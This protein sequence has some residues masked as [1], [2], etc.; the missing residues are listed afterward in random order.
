MKVDLLF[1]I[2]GRDIPLKHEYPLYSALSDLLG[3]DIHENPDIGVFPIRGIPGS[4]FLMLTEKSKLRI[5]LPEEQIAAIASRLC[6]KRLMIGPHRLHVGAMTVRPLTPAPVL[7]SSMVTIRPMSAK[8]TYVK[9]TPEYLLQSITH[10]CEKMGIKAS[11]EIGNR[12]GKPLGRSIHIKG[13]SILGF[14]VIAS[15]LSDDDSLRLQEQGLGGRR[16]LGC[17]L[18]LPGKIH[19]TVC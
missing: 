17:G 2:V 14:P 10:A 3:S 5:R 15:N 19:A 13:C 6:C 4:D 16:K 12:D 11:L 7:K 18:F 9:P 1:N 8:K